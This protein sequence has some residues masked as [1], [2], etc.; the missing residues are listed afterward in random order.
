MGKEKKEEKRTIFFLLLNLLNDDKLKWER[1][2][3]GRENK[4]KK[5]Y[6]SQ[7]DKLQSHIGQKTFHEAEEK[8]KERKS[9][10]TRFGAISD[11]EHDPHWEFYFLPWRTK[12]SNIR[13]NS[14]ND[15]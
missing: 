8:P 10:Y 12:Q 1:E 6:Y 9:H 7:S 13:S 3:G 2:G 11:T 15:R 4:K 5:K 14:L